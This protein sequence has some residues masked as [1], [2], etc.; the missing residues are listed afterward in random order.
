MSESENWETTTAD[1]FW[2]EMAP[3]DHVLQIYDTDE[4]FLSSLIGFV[5]AGINA[6]YCTIV[7]ATQVHLDILDARL[8]TLGM[9]PQYLKDADIFIPLNAEDTLARFMVNGWPD[10][11][12]FQ[13]TIGSILERASKD[14]R[15]VRA[16]GEMVAVLW[17]QG[18]HG[19]TVALEALWNEFMKKEAFSLFCAYPKAGF[20]QDIRKSIEAICSFHTKQVRPATLNNHL[21]YY[22]SV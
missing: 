14:K 16:F 21:Q 12:L 15:R 18:K 9:Q 3:C 17:A 1:I 13:H 5:G 7:I 19:A 10:K 22:T 2:G 20:T 6:G 8:Q 4:Q 11:L